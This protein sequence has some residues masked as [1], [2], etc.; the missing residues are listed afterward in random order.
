MP[1]DSLWQVAPAKLKY[2]LGMTHSM[3]RTLICFL[4]GLSLLMPPGMCVCQFVRCEQRPVEVATHVSA[5]SGKSVNC[6]CGCRN[7]VAE[8]RA[9]NVQ[10]DKWSAR[11][12]STCVFG[13]TTPSDHHT[14]ACPALEAPDHSKVA[15][16]NNFP[17][18]APGDLNS[19]AVYAV[20]PPSALHHLAT[21]AKKSSAPPLYLAHCTLLV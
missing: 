15:E 17:L 12:A 14:P 1:N 5:V 9:C 16:Q 8:G 11:L 13:S 2:L 7:G 21:S 20:A 18:T 6:C 19:A 3:L 4:V 10:K